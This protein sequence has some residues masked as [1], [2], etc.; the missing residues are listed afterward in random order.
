MHGNVWEWCED[1]FHGDYDSAPI[2]GSAR[3]DASNDSGSKIMRGGSWLYGP[4]DC[5]SAYRNGDTADYRLIGIG[6][7][8][9]YSSARILF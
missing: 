9:V 7:R 8:V 2:D 6:F 4:W 3:T 5:R 1:D